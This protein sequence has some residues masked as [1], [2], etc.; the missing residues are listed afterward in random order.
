M[1]A[2]V[3]SRRSSV[4]ALR[5]A[6]KCSELRAFF[7]HPD[8]AFLSPPL[9]DDFEL[10][11]KDLTLALMIS[12]ISS[13]TDWTPR[14]IPCAM[15]QLTM[16]D[17]CASSTASN[18]VWV[19]LVADFFLVHARSSRGGA[20][21]S[22]LALIARRAVSAAVAQNLL[23]GAGLGRAIDDG[24]RAPSS[25]VLQNRERPNVKLRTPAAAADLGTPRRDRARAGH[26][27]SHPSA[28]IKGAAAPRRA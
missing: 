22:Q 28:G 4:S 3:H 8:I 25:N 24:I 1:V 16:A 6:G 17:F 18:E 7:T 13:R 26:A 2:Q 10:Q 19:T 27:R 23:A 11:T 9:L 5:L 21:E 20:R 15:T 12:L 14:L